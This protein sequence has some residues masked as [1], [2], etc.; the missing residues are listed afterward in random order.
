M[1]FIVGVVDPTR[2]FVLRQRVLRPH[3]SLVVVEEESRVPGSLTFGAAESMDAPVLSTATIYPEAPPDDLRPIVELA[4][5][6]RPYRLRAVAT[7]EGQRSRGLGKAVLES[8]VAHL[9]NEGEAVLWCYA[10][11]PARNFY[12]REGFSSFGEVFV[13][14]DFGLH[15]VMF[16][17]IDR[18]S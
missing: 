14:E 13:I 4:R 18:R 16:R 5:T 7:T 15:V 1:S 8:I 17:A 9:S 11:I 3:Q 12:L 6:R 10:R 2:T